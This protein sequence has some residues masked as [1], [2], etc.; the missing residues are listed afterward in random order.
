MLSDFCVNKSQLNVL[1]FPRCVTQNGF[2]HLKRP[3]KSLK[4]IVRKVTCDFLLVFY[5][6]YVSIL[7]RL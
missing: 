4:V 6:N 5:C 3:S 2:K 1:H 7:Y